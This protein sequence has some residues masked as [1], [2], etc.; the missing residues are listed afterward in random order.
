MDKRTT[1]AL[2]FLLLT[3]IFLLNVLSV[4]HKSATYDE[5]DHLRYGEQVLLFNTDK[6]VETAEPFPHIVNGVMPVSALNAIPLKIGKSLQPGKLKNFLEDLT[7]GRAV[8]VLFSLLLAFYVFKWAAELYGAVPGLFSLI[9]YAFSPNIIAHS[10]LITVDL[11]PT[12]LITISTYYFWRFIKSGGWKRAVLS[13]SVLGFS[14]LTKYTCAFLYP[15]FLV[16]AVIRYAPELPAG[17]YSDA[18]R[19]LKSFGKFSILFML[20]GL[21]VVNAGF[22]FHGSLTPLGKYRFNSSLFRSVQSR[23]GPLRHLP[24]PLPYPYL[25]GLDGHVHGRETIPSHGPLYLLGKLRPA[26]AFKGYYFVAF[27]YKVPIAI[28]IFLLLSII[29]YIWNRKKYNFLENELFL[30]CPV[31]FFAVYFNYIFTTNIGIR[32][33][34]IIFP[35]LH[36]FSGSLVSDWRIRS[37]RSKIVILALTGYLIVS[38]LSYFPHYLS[39]FNELVWDRKQAYK[40]LADS[41]IDWGQNEIYLREYKLKNPHIHINPETP[42]TGKVVVSINRLVGITTSD[43][44]KY[45]WLRDNFEPVDHIAYSYLVYDIPAD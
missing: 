2:V 43:P 1:T 14:L 9:L 19:R 12:C 5:P 39:Y 22:L 17:R 33:F 27:L 6:F 20:I 3:I 4:R 15:I 41:N 29:H 40:I 28:Q 34:I 26:T 16:I 30:L 25:Q 42:V 31:I 32:H 45:G 38:V 11:Y 8:T 10:R 21:I 13:A 7:A 24:V 35:F 37:R 23:L 36:I 18:G 44:E